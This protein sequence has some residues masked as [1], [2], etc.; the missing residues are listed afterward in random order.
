MSQQA[1]ERL[2]PKLG[3]LYAGL[4]ED[5][6]EV[7]RAIVALAVSTESE[8]DEVG[9]FSASGINALIAVTQMKADNANQNAMD[10]A[11]KQQRLVQGGR[12]FV[13]FDNLMAAFRWPPG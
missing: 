1:L 10:G 12:G 2:R 11:D 13:H 4:P 6:Q 9:G 3:D 5:E 8:G 7:L